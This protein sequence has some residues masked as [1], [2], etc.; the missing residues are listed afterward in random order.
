VNASGKVPLHKCIFGLLLLTWFACHSTAQGVNDEFWP[1]V[2]GYLRLNE[3]TRLLLRTSFSAD[4]E[5]RTWQGDFGMH[6]DFALR[7]VFR[8]E[9]S[10][11]ED[12]F[13]KRFLSF[14]AGYRYIT[15][16]GS[17]APYLEHRWLVEM[18]SRFPVPGRLLFIDRNRGEMR[19]ISSKGF[20][21]R[22]RN[23]LQLE[24][25]FRPVGGFRF[26]PYA[27]G[28]LFYD[29][30]YDKWNRNRYAI[31]MRFPVRHHF[32]PELYFLHQNDSEATP[33]HVNAFGVTFNFYF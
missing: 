2:D 3:V 11:D 33:P 32:V 8:R 29:T 28:E 12:V 27:Y 15:S 20:S 17:G 13:S 22:Y 19:F 21:T 25:D 9:L 26:T 24:R 5:T 6:F 4:D 1:E 31:G 14:L 18:T 16:L 7:P 30:R 10:D 23:K